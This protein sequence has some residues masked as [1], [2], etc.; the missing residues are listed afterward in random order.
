MKT[1][2]EYEFAICNIRDEYDSGGSTKK[3]IKQSIDDLAKKMGISFDDVYF[4]FC[5]CI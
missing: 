3:E 2:Q 4:E 1:L 5:A